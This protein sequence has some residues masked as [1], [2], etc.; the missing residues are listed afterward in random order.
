MRDLKACRQNLEYSPA[1]RVIA[2]YCALFGMSM[3]LVSL[4]IQDAD[5]IGSRE[6]MH[7]RA[8]AF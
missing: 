6:R 4:G 5:N 3:Q 1:T 2:I 7:S 8:T